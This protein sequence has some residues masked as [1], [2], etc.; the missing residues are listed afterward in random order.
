VWTVGQ[1][2]RH[3]VENISAPSVRPKTLAGNRTAI[4]RHL[5]PNFGSHRI[6]NVEPEHFE[7]LYQKMQKSGLK[8]ATA[9]HIH[10]A[11][12]NA[13]REAYRRGHVMRNPMEFV[14][15]PR[16]VEE[17]VEPFEAEEIQ[18]L[19][20]AALARR[21]GVRFVVALALGGRQG[22]VLGLKWER[23]NRTTKVLRVKK[24]LQ[25]HPWQ[26]GCDDPRACAAMN[27]RTKKC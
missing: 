20:K 6:T 12:R 26:Y 1:C 11:A 14:K 16:V 23:L 15:A 3:W 5:I 18:L 17:E 22:E 8:R 27:H 9:H 25:R 4:Y 2:P 24:S 19:I 21:N 10:R 13:F 7:K